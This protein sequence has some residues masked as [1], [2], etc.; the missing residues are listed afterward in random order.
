[1]R[2]FVLI[3]LTA[4]LSLVALPQSGLAMPMAGH[5]DHLHDCPGCAE[6]GTDQERT[7]AG[8]PDCPHIAGC[9][10]AA[11]PVADS[12]ALAVMALRDVH[13]LPPSETGRAVWLDRDLPPPRA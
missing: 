7:P 13:P 2:I 6:Y 3:L 5:M 4:F 8:H 9:A 12:P 10:T 1:M 11:L